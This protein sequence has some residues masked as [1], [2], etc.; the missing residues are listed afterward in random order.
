MPD[1]ISHRAGGVLTPPLD[2]TVAAHF[3]YAGQIGGAEHM[4]YNLMHGIARA[5]ARAAAAARASSAS[6]ARAW[7]AR[8]AAMR[9]C[10]PTISSR[11]SF[12]AASAA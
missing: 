3:V 2:L 11:R 10:S 9:S 5:G 1:G 4:F 7:A 12:H 6:S 8:C